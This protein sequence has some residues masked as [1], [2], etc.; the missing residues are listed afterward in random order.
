ME[1]SISYINSLSSDFTFYFELFKSLGDSD[2]DML[3][4]VEIWQN[5]ILKELE[6]KKIESMFSD[7]VDYGDCFLDIHSGAGGTESNDWASMLLRMYLRW[8]EE[9]IYKAELVS[10]LHGEEAGIKYATLKIHGVNA[11]GWLKNETGVHRLVR[12]SP[13]NS[14]GKR[15]TS[16]ASVYAYPVL[17]ENITIKIENSDLRVDTYRSSGAGGQ[18]VNTTDSA[19]RITH[20]PSGVVVQSQSSRSQHKNKEECMSMLRSK[21]YER[22]QEKKKQEF[23]KASS[24]KTEIG[25]GNQIRSYVLHPYRM[26]KDL[27]TSH[28]ETNTDY[29]LDG[30]ITGFMRSNIIKN[31]GTLSG[32]EN[33]T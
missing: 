21:L 14:A 18:H 33:L 20:I 28:Q 11:Y 19:V 8:C 7:E 29:V 23:E 17:D 25:W 2:S 24:V 3:Q 16:F 13:F 5:K 1:D 22:E 4:E 27:R 12:I 30:G 10:Q 6:Q 15:H 31:M 32:G 26:V 9:N